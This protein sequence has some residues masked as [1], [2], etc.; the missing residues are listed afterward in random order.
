MKSVIP[1]T[2]L[3]KLPLLFCLLL[4]VSSTR[5]QDA[6]FS[7]FYAAPVQLNPAFAGS[8]FA[9]R[10][11]VNYRSQWF[12]FPNAYTTFS[13]SYEQFLER[14]NSG[15][16]LT[17]MSD[18]AGDGIYKTLSAGFVYSYRLQILDDLFLKGGLELGVVQ[19]RLDW[20]RLIFLDQIDDLNGPGLPSQEERPERLTNSYVDI[21]SGFLLYSSQFYLG[22]T[23]KHLNRPSQSYLTINENLQEGI[24]MRF[25]VHAGAEFSLSGNNK[26]G[27]Q[28]FLSPNVIFVRQ[29]AFV[30]INA[31]AYM[32]VGAFYFGSWFRHT[33]ENPDAVIFL[34]G[35][36]QGIFKLG[37][38][39]DWTISDFGID[40]GGAHELS[41]ILNLDNSESYKKRRGSRYNDCFQIFR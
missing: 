15:V 2:K 16:G 37:Y 5:A 22:L 7:Q 41:L 1:P 23:L 17:V 14:T 20:E 6:V 9:P 25:S 11:A 35:L 27:S 40:N 31:G 21:S 12:N 32:G 19:E 10:F 36:K 28:T 39:F 34:A 24:P 29:G 8:T 13:A 26:R 33:V 38:S 3:K 30:Q 4:L 18:N